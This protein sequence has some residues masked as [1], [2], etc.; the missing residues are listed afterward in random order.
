MYFPDTKRYKELNRK[1]RDWLITLDVNDV[2]DIY[3]EKCSEEVLKDPE[4]WVRTTLGGPEKRIILVSFANSLLRESNGNILEF[5]TWRQG[6]VRTLCLISKPGN[7]KTI[8]KP[9]KDP[10][11]S[12]AVPKGSEDNF[13]HN[14]TF[15]ILSRR[16]AAAWRT[17]AW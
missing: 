6:H 9:Q 3:D 1:F 17:S 8:E 10:C 2:K 13:E 11:K 14:P 12:Q 4:G 15:S 5:H 7:A 16:C